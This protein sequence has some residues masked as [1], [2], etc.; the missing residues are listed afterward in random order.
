MHVPLIYH[1]EPIFGFDLGTRTAKMLQLK[2]GAKQTE[3][4]GYGYANFPEGTIVEGILV[5]PDEIAK[6]LKPLM[7]QMTFGKITATRVAASLPCRS[8]HTRA[9]TT[10]HESGRPGPGCPT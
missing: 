1:E 10:R 4:M 7:K 9:R 5:D 6:A 2:P 8:L 3:V